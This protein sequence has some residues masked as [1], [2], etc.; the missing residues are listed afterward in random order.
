MEFKIVECYY[1]VTVT[2]W[3][4]LGNQNKFLERLGDV[5]EKSNKN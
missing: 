1:S 5:V 2:K 4:V 3:S